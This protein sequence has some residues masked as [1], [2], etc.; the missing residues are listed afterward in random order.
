MMEQFVLDTM[1]LILYLEGRK[2]PI[3]VKSIFEKADRDEV[4]IH[5]PAMVLAELGYLSE[6]GKI[7][8]SLE[9]VEAFLSDKKA[10]AVYPQTLEVIKSTFGIDDI[11]ELHDRIIAGTAKLLGAK[12]I[13]NDPKIE[14]SQSVETV[15]R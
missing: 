5:I 9:K 3:K 6:R 12:L 7:E 4:H 2:L 13:T 1:A 10:Y 11:P 8:L 14:A 15:W